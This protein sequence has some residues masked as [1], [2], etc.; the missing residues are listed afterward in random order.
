MLVEQQLEVLQ[1][2]QLEQ[3]Q[4]ELHAASCSERSAISSTS[5]VTASSSRSSWPRVWADT[6]FF[7][8]SSLVVEPVR[9]GAAHAAGAA[10][11]GRERPDDREGP[12]APP[13]RRAA[14]PPPQPVLVLVE[15][16]LEV[17]QEQ[18]LEQEQLELHAASCSERSAI[19]STSK[20]TASSSR[21]SWPRD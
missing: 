15:Q 3:E 14:Q 12:G 16:Q 21:S 9:S 17:L 2:Q 19:S 10:R 20:V 4:L 8:L 6:G 18:Q 7:F 1:E 13:R 5:K 11:T